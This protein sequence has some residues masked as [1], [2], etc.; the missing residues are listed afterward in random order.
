MLRHAS[1][2]VTLVIA[3]LIDLNLGA[4]HVLPPAF[5]ESGIFS[6]A[7]P[8]KWKGKEAKHVPILS[9]DGRKVTVQN[10]HGQA[11]DHH[12]VSVWIEN[13]NGAVVG[14]KEL[15]ESTAEAT[16]EFTL[17]EATRGSLTAWSFC[18]LHGAWR[19]EPVKIPHDE[20]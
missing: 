14:V 3:C 9:I 6:A 13:Q 5:K 12:I 20:L 15:H 18:N 10:P 4:V 11:E 19:S 2:F 8:G 1:C 16:V 17:E 7:E